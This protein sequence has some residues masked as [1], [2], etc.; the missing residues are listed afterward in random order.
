M[1]T[2]SKIALVTGGSQGLGKDMALQLAHHG[3]DVVLT[4]HRHPEAAEAVVAQIRATGQQ[5]FALPFD[6]ADSRT[7]DPFV[8]ELTE[9]LTA[10]TGRP[11]IDFL[12]N[13]AGSGADTLIADTPEAV[14]DELY[15]I[16]VKGPYLLTQKVLPF[17]N[18]GGGVINLA[19]G[20]TRFTT[21][22]R[23]AYATM[24]GAVETFTRYLAKE[25]GPRGITANSVA[26]GI[27]QTSFTQATFDQP[28]NVTRLQSITA[29]GRTGKPEDIGGVVAFLCSDEARWITGQRLEVSGGMNL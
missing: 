29:L 24:K 20:L 22:G 21:L 10:Q 1:A 25:V 6:V 4:Y 26:P 12:I 18:D 8:R 27:I 13:N 17:L 16:H 11:N 28:E 9:R 19:S 14:L 7:F 23:S 5:A 15:R 3:H 2:T